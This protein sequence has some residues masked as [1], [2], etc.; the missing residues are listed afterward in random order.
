MYDYGGVFREKLSFVSLW[1]GAIA[2]ATISR[3]ESPYEGFHNAVIA[4]VD[5][6]IDPPMAGGVD[7]NTGIAISMIRHQVTEYI[8]GD[9]WLCDL[10]NAINQYERDYTVK[11]KGVSRDPTY[12]VTP[13]CTKREI[14]VL[15]YDVL[16]RFISQTIASSGF[17]LTSKMLP[18]GKSSY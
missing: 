6:L 16:L 13:R 15:K 7:D 5:I 12:T 17:G 9:Q 2:R 14:D 4:L 3:S 11:V 10:Q 18:K 8:E 1:M